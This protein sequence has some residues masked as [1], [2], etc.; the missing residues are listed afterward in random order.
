MNGSALTVNNLASMF[1]CDLSDLGGACDDFQ[2]YDFRY[3]RLDQTER[4]QVI[5]D[6]LRRIDGFTQVGEHRHDIWTDAWSDVAA[7]YAKSGGDLTALEPHFMGATPVIRLLG[8]Y[9]RPKHPSFELHFFRVFRRW[10]FDT[11]L[12]P[13][14][15]VHEF[16]CGSG[17]NLATLAN[18][19][20][21]VTAYGWD[22]AESA[23]SL[24]RQVALDHQLAIS[25]DR[26]DFFNPTP[27]ITLGPGTMAMTF[28]ALEQTGD[29]CGLMLEWLRERRPDLVI[30][31]EPI[32][33]FY[34]D[35]KLHDHLALR[36]H[37]HRRYLHG[38]LTRLR[39]WEAQGQIEIVTARR[40]GFG[41]LF[42]EGYSLVVWRPL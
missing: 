42:H 5:V 28:C 25:A 21:D 12:K 39:N 14:K 41:S 19:R 4:D 31:M 23:V 26:F 29:S 16:G 20:P 30:S 11:Y 36:Y 35:T 9:A 40:L 6:V 17:F 33:E 24:L 1:G 37:E 32:S 13:A 38:Y 3:D 7:R 34:D 2:Q 27:D 8:D 15:V 22:W 10:L 18:L